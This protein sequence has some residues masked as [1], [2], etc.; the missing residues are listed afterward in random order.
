MLIGSGQS[1][2]PHGTPGSLKA[3][4]KRMD[5]GETIAMLTRGGQFEAAKGMFHFRF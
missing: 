2:P 5:A 4:G 3:R 1:Q